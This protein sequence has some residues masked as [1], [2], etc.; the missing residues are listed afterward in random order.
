MRACLYVPIFCALL[1]ACSGDDHSEDPIG[2]IGGSGGIGGAAG[3]A[4]GGQSGTSGQS[5]AGGQSGTSGQGG[6]GG[7]ID[8]AGADAGD[9][10]D[11]IDSGSDSGMVSTGPFAI[12]ALPFPLELGEPIA[13][14]DRQWSFVAF[15]ESRCANGTPT[16]IAINPIANAQ[17][18]L[19][20]MQGGGACWNTEMCFVSMSSVHL[21]DT[22]DE[23]VTLNEAANLSG[24]F[25]HDNAANPFKDF[26]Y[27]YMPY[28]T[29]DLH[30]GTAT[31]TYEGGTIHH[32]GG[33]NV[34]EYLARLVPTFPEIEGVVVSGISAGGFGATFNWWRFQGAF[35]HARVDVL[36]DAG[37]IVDP[38]ND[39]WSTMIEAWQL[40]LPPG[41]DACAERMS[42]FLPFYGEHLIAPR[43]YALVGFM[44]DAVIGSF[45]ELTGE[46][47]AAELLDRR[48]NA[49]ANQKTFFLAGAQH[50]IIGEGAFTMASD[51]ATFL[52]W[53]LQ[54]ASDDPAWDHAGP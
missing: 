2:G 54:M 1:L 20:F 45:F 48:M 12:D 23:T 7:V 3:G 51:G 42:A 9:A 36:D 30:I 43:R 8:D 10:S 40:A 29:G 49:A 44:S 37:L 34:A 47:I 39:H 50:S 6:A 16:G 33:R 26:A 35:P 22:V 15:P 21:A 5:G 19:V 32:Y 17:G 41:C 4:A 53:L 52:P 13:A 28:C 14:P 46:Q 25:D 27:V 24:L 31:K 38:A 11:P 18:L